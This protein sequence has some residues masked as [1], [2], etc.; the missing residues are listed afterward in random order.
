MCLSNS[1]LD[2][3]EKAANAECSYLEIIVKGER[4]FLYL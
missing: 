3:K 1:A 2:G 4:I